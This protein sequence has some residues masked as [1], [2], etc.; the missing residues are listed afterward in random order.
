MKL[1]ISSLR[2]VGGHLLLHWP[3]CGEIAGL[4]SCSLIKKP[5]KK[6]SGETL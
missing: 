1:K 3:H 4:W 2:F 6:Q 5:D